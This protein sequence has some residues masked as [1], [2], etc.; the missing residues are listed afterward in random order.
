MNRTQDRDPPRPPPATAAGSPRRAR[1]MVAEDV[2]SA[3]DHLLDREAGL[4]RR[5]VAIEGE[6]LPAARDLIA[7]VVEELARIAADVW[8]DDDPSRDDNPDDA[9]PDPAGVAWTRDARRWL[10][11]GRPPLPR[12]HSRE[13]HARQLARRLRAGAEGLTLVLRCDDPAP[14]TGRRL[15]VARAAEW[16]ARNADADVWILVRPEFAD[17]PEWDPVNHGAVHWPR[18]D[19]DLRLDGAAAANDDDDPGTGTGIA[20]ETA[21]V[22]AATRDAPPERIDRFQP[23]PRGKPHPYSPGEQLLYER[24]GRDRTLGPLFVFNQSVATALGNA[25]LV[26][27]VWKAGK[28]VVEIDGYEHHGNRYAFS[29]DRRRDYELTLSGYLVLRLPHD[30]VVADVESALAKMREFVDYRSGHAGP[31]STE[32]PVRPAS[33]SDSDSAE[34]RP[35]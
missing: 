12:G 7:T 26:D 2:P 30:E 28:I 35:A 4:G 24:L 20:A 27:L 33:D 17:S 8:S 5:V 25:F 11:A 21:A 16:L 32:S 1:M 3:L 29:R 15:G 14:R 22:V 6:P 19:L 10:R 18:R 31:E 9:P 23:P 13:T 34:D